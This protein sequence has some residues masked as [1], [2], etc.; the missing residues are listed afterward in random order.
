MSKEELIFHG[1]KV[2]GGKA[3]GKALVSPEPVCFLGGVQIES[4]IVTEKGHPLEGEKLKDRVLI[5]PIGKG[6]TGGSYLIYATVKNGQGP[7]AVINAKA[8]PVTVTGCILAEVPMLVE[9]EPD[10]ITGIATGDWVEIDAD[11][12][13]VRVI[14]T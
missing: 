10:P 4:G 3:S 13:V 8:D 1:R 12:G 7:C 5:F 6:S 11:A 14:K 2:V 9:L